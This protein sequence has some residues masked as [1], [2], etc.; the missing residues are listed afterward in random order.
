MIYSTGVEDFGEYA[1]K[2]ADIIREVEAEPIVFATASITKH[3]NENFSFPES[4][5]AFNEMQLDFGKKYSVPVVD[6][7]YAWLR[8]LGDNPTEE[9]V[10]RLYH[11]DKGHPGSSGTYLYSCLLYAYTTKCSPVGLVSKFPNIRD[12]IAIVD[13]ETLQHVAWEQYQDDF[14]RS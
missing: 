1:K 2:F 4:T 8:Y 13:A 3:Y 5:I 11:K 14:C 10:L 7:G 12:G 9:A 6:A